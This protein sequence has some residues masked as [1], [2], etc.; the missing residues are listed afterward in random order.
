MIC[1]FCLIGIYCSFFLLDDPNEEAR[2]RKVIEAVGTEEFEDTVHHFSTMLAAHKKQNRLSIARRMS[3][4]P[5]AHSKSQGVAKPSV[6]E[7][8]GKR[9]SL[10]KSVSDTSSL[11]SSG[12]H[13][14]NELSPRM[15]AEQPPRPQPQQRRSH[16]LMKVEPGSFAVE[17]R[18]N[19]EGEIPAAKITRPYR[20]LF[21]QV[22]S[23]E[24]NSPRGTSLDSSPPSEA[25]GT[26]LNS[27]SPASV[28][29]PSEAPG[30]S[31]DGIFVFDDGRDL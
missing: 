20:A 28:R 17:K 4:P 19:S 13:E 25:L 8:A 30:T 27:H 6:A 12:V 11:D 9:K 24:A 26:S 3:L 21:P 16:D 23:D 14:E 1:S 7:A 31:L 15:T 29:P 22:N 5:L 18:R 2:L 10:R